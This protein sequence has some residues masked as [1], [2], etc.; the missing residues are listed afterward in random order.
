[1]MSNE[2]KLSSERP[3]PQN[4]GRGWSDI[5]ALARRVIRAANMA[6]MTHA[7]L[8]LFAQKQSAVSESGKKAG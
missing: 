8:D 7:E 3:A 1:M 4:E 5:E 2:K 6:V